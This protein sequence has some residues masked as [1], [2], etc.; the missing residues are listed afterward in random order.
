[1]FVSHLPLE[2]PQTQNGGYKGPKRRGKVLL[3]ACFEGVHPRVLRTSCRGRESIWKLPFPPFHA[4]LPNQGGLCKQRGTLP[5]ALL[6]AVYT[7][8]KS[9]LP[10][11]LFLSLLHVHARTHARRRSATLFSDSWKCCCFSRMMNGCQP[12]ATMKPGSSLF[13]R[14]PPRQERH[15]PRKRNPNRD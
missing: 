5:L 14:F 12:S 13:C 11:P 10:P 15:Q 8:V 9:F 7:P 1:M 4:L 2:L 3:V 6:G